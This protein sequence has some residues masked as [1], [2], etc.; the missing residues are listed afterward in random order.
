MYVFYSGVMMQTTRGLTHAV[1]QGVPVCLVINKVWFIRLFASRCRISII[2]SLTVA[3]QV[4]RLITELKLP[5]G[6]AYHKLLHTV[7]DV[8]NVLSKAG[9]P[10]TVSP[11]LG[12][13]PRLACVTLLPSQLLRALLP[14]N[15]C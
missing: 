10:D 1:Q 12:A 8:N 7:E 15:V 4:D 13:P 14:G 5:P 6:D 3:S 11:E 9:Y 2:D